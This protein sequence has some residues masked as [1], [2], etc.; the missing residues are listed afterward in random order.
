MITTGIFPDSFNK[1][2]NHTLFK[3]GEPSLLINYRP[4]SLLPTIS[5]TFERII[6]NQMYNHFN[7]NN[8]LAEQQYGFRKL[9]STEFSAVKLTDGV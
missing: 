6:H 1:I 7:D 8:L 9:Q 5:K 2:K 4:V 3:K